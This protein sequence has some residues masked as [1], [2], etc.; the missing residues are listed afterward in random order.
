[1]E[2]MLDELL[3][4]GQVENY[5]LIM[6]LEAF[7]LGMQ[8]IVSEILSFTSNSYRG[9]LYASY[10]MAMPSL[11]SWGWEAFASKFVSEI[12]L[13]KIKISSHMTNPAMWDHI[14]V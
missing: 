4:E 9:R 12:T 14:S 3:I 5:V 13:R 11:L 1:M 7:S 6:N 10:F 2:F 8:S